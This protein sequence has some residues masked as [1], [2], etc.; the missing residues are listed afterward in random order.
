MELYLPFEKDIKDT[1]KL[2]PVYKTKFIMC[3]CGKSI[4]V[5]NINPHKKTI[6]HKEALN[7]KRKILMDKDDAKIFNI[8]L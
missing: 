1:Q 7:R 3:S 8:T 2:N 4:S 6:I 5:N